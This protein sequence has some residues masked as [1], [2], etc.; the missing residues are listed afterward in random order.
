MAEKKIINS[1]ISVDT[2]ASTTGSITSGTHIDIANVTSG[3]F[4][5]Y[6]G[7]TFRGGLGT[8]NW[9][10]SGSANDSAYYVSGDNSFFIHTNN[11]NRF[12]INKDVSVFKP[13][14]LIKG[15]TTDSSKINFHIDS[16]GFQMLDSWDIKDGL[17]G[18]MT[19]LEVR[20]ANMSNANSS[21]PDVTVS[22]I[23]RTLTGGGEGVIRISN[24][25]KYRKIKGYLK[26]RS[27]GSTD[28][29]RDSSESISD[30]TFMDGIAITGFD[31]AGSNETWLWGVV[32]ANYNANEVVSNKPSFVG[33]NY[34]K[35][36][37]NHAG[38]SQ[39]DSPWNGYWWTE[40]SS[41]GN[42]PSIIVNFEREISSQLDGDIEI[43]LM[44]DQGKSNE[45][46][47][48]EQYAI[49]LADEEPA[50]QYFNGDGTNV[51]TVPT[52]GQLTI[53][54]TQDSSV[55]APG[56]GLTIVRE[57]DNSDI[58]FIN[59]TGGAFN[60][61]S[62]GGTPIK[63]RSDG[64]TALTLDTSQNAAFAGDV[65]INSTSN[66]GLTLEHATRPTFTFTDG[67]N[68]AYLGLESGGAIITGT[69]DN[70]FSIRSPR[71]IVFG[72][73]GTETARINT[74]G[75]ASFAGNV[76]APRFI[77]SSTGTTTPVNRYLYTDNTN[78]G[79]G[80]LIIQ[81]GGG[82]AGYGGAINL[83]SHSH[84][85]KPGWVTA[86]ISSGSGGKF[87]VNSSGTAGGTDVFTV[88][89]SGNATFAGD[90]SVGGNLSIQTMSPFDFSYK[91]YT[92]SNT[93]GITALSTA[94]YDDW[95]AIGNLGEG[96]GVIYLN[97][98]FDAH[99]AYS[100]TLSRGYHGSNV[101]NIT[102]TSATYNPNGSYGNLRGIRIIKPDDGS[103]GATAN[104][105]I[106][107]RLVKTSSSAGQFKM[108]AKAWGGGYND[109]TGRFD[110]LDNA[111][112]VS[113][114]GTGHLVIAQ[115]NDISDPN[116]GGHSHNKSIYAA[117]DIVS[118]G[119]V[120]AK[121]GLINLGG[122]IMSNDGDNGSYDRVVVDYTG[123]NSGDINYTWTPQTTPGSG[124]VR[125]DFRFQNTNG[126]SSTTNNLADLYV[127]GKLF[128][129]GC[130][131]ASHQLEN[132][133]SNGTVLTLKSTGDNRYL[134][135]QTDHVYSNG[136]MHFG[137]N[138]NDTEFRGDAY[139]FRYDYGN[140]KLT[141]SSNHYILFD[142]GSG[143]YST[144]IGAGNHAPAGYTAQTQN[145]WVD[146]QSKGGMHVVL[147]T[148]GAYN[149]SENSFDH[150]T[151]WQDNHDNYNAR[152]FYVTN[153]GNVYAKG[154]VVAYQSS[155]MSDVRLKKDIKP[156]TDAL[157]KVK[158]L[159]GVNFTWKKDNKKSIGFVAQEIEK[160]LPELVKTT[161]AI[162]DPE[163]QYK[164]VNYS[165]VVAVL[166]EA[167]K[168]Q[169]KQIDEL[170]KLIK[171][172]NNL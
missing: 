103:G 158:K 114:D 159:N 111:T 26:V 161:P 107:V 168:D 17:R 113:G 139:L 5:F 86:G 102:C 150:F 33:T 123:Y 132:T 162:D 75:Q 152:Q 18:N 157:D 6:D 110:F 42:E 56:D 156:I 112:N 146:V 69:A 91:D 71:D 131:S 99:S 154:D 27:G 9:A 41:D 74:S 50:Y 31:N 67:T 11:A 61:V 53:V 143:D 84:A 125:T 117:K 155:N 60:I 137:Q 22:A 145:Y 90:A 4:R 20:T 36:L 149:S 54:Q 70:D 122:M 128:A 48:L 40:N 171:D 153:V 1:K 64:T 93:V 80:R 28:G 126:T 136:K 43:R 116:L 47:G 172:V 73:N 88:D 142:R 121:G 89:T 72:Y 133:T 81:S 104:Y 109:G 169:Q 3:A 65:A 35:F 135:L 164:S 96:E 29:W 138:G 78:A 58:G 77:L 97:L 94:T 13:T 163:K 39:G 79:T 105:S 144:K 165:N 44:C 68:N 140:I 45:D 63:L 76:T 108:H 120:A 85:S 167:I 115:I 92:P 148:D 14:Y 24:R 19:S 7:S 118:E 25:R 62:T 147:N 16:K 37:N 130:S 124:I 59:M 95:F 100:F 55:T 170:K 134:Y 119:K 38:G 127:G 46:V 106:Q 151:I 101:G 15:D 57:A 2:T 23:G 34:S 30:T 51:S 66:V 129:S 87:T 32:C 141:N 160:V 83:F 10:L 98:K 49:W 8:N 166:V 12:E 52:S 82:S 21:Y